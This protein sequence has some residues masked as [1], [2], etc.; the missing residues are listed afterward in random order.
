MPSCLI[1]LLEVRKLTVFAPSDLAAAADVE[2][3]NEIS[4][5]D[6]LLACR[7][8]GLVRKSAYKDVV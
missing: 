1:R 2:G 6:V 7:E 5:V 3:S 4:F 8:E